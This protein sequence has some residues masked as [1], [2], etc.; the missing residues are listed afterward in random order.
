M[1]DTHVWLLI[2]LVHWDLGRVLDPVLYGTSDVQNDLH[3]FSK[4]GTF[5]L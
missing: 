4:V 1:D 3:S 2:H 5:L